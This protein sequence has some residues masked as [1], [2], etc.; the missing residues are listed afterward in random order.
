M[1][2][3][4]VRARI[5]AGC[6]AAPRSRDPQTYFPIAVALAG[7]DV[8]ARGPA[9]IRYELERMRPTLATETDAARAVNFALARTKNA[10]AS[11]LRRHPDAIP[12]RNAPQ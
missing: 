9:A 8:R 7:P 11:W 3:P 1:A 6:R 5:S 12:I 4:E 10:L 2:T